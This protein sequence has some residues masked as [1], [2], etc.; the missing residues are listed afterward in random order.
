MELYKFRK[1]R[2]LLDVNLDD[3]L[4]MTRQNLQSLNT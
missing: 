3:K 1:E 4:G 2:N